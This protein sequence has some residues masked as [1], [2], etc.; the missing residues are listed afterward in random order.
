MTYEFTPVLLPFALAAGSLAIPLYLSGNLSD[1]RLRASLLLWTVPVLLWAV[2]SLL[3]LA[4]TSITDELL[5]HNLRFVGPALGSTGYFLFAAAYTSRPRWFRR[6][7]LAGL[8]VVPALTVGLVWTNPMHAL[9]RASVDA[10]ATG[11]FVM[12]FTPG[13]WFLVHAVYSYLLIATGSVWLGHRLWEFR[14]RRLFRGQIVAVFLGVLFV[15]VANL[16]FNAGLTAIDWTPV[17]GAAAAIVF[18][19]AAS[20][21][22]LFD[23]SPIAREVVVENMDSGMVVT[24]TDGEIVDANSSAAAILGTQLDDLI[25]TPLEDTFVASIA[26]VDDVDETS[27]GTD[28][29]DVEIDGNVRYYDVSVSP[30][31]DP[32]ES[33]VG[34][35]IVFSEVTSRVERRRRL[36]EQKERLERHNDRLDRFSSMVSHDL[37]N[38]LT[39]ASGYL[40]MARQTGRTPGADLDVRLPTGFEIDAEPDLLRSVLENLFRNAT[41]HNDPPLTVVIGTLDGDADRGSGAGDRTRGFYVADD[42]QG[43]PQDSRTTVFEHGY[44]TDE[45]GTGIGL[46]IVSEF[47]EAHDWEITVTDG[48]DGGAR[49]EIVTDRAATAAGATPAEN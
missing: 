33:G 47:V 3:R 25:G 46:S 49:F 15:T 39:T 30:I 42:G 13:P 14:N 5:W 34:R 18:V 28:T 9:V 2:S 20:E 11:P 24:D 4:A 31:T 1:R 43:I 44:T 12:T 7:R 40:E 36:Q 38:P 23:L 48:P 22:R 26:T 37:R 16:S 27:R 8:F 6:R 35:V 21:Y 45:D 17:A 29:I 32:A 19:G 41:D 10:A